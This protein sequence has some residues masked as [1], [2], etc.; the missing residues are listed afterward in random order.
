LY[1]AGLLAAILIAAVAL[2]AHQ[3]LGI[4]VTHYLY[5]F[6]A[7]TLVR[8]MAPAIRR[9]PGFAPGLIAGAGVVLM[10]V[11][12]ELVPL[13]NTHPLRFDMPVTL[14]GVMLIAMLA[15]AGMPRARAL[16]CSAPIQFLGRIS[17]SVY[18]ANWL[19][20]HTLG[21]IMLARNL[22]GSI[23][24]A[25]TV[26]LLTLTTVLLLLPL[27]WVLHALVERPAVAWSRRHGQAWAA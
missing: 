17:Y 14:G 10:A 26:T 8:D 3:K 20:I 22:P 25:A 21:Q 9:L 2:N 13:H 11:T 7:G 15:H 12:G 6:Y 5:M 27:G 19:A 4:D 24:L 16:M 1:R 18:L 23:G